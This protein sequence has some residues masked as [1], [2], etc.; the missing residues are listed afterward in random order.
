M[1]RSP[2]FS[3]ITKEETAMAGSAG[4]FAKVI[5]CTGVQAQPAGKMER[6]TIKRVLECVPA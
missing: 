5:I 4:F 3:Q 6:S 1:G 2:G